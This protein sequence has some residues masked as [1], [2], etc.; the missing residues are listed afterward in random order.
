MTHLNR[1]WLKSFRFEQALTHNRVDQIHKLARN[2]AVSIDL[3][4]PSVK[5]V[6]YHYEINDDT[7][8]LLN[9]KERYLLWVSQWKLIYAELTGLIR[10]FKKMRKTLNFPH[11]DHRLQT[12]LGSNFKNA[13]EQSE[14]ALRSL[15][16]RQL[17]RLAETAQV[18]LNARYLGKM[19]SSVRWAR[20]EREFLNDLKEICSRP[21]PIVKDLTFDDRIPAHDLEGTPYVYNTNDRT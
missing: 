3:G 14:D 19:A 8:A 18:L 12:F 7:Y 2:F 13:S 17:P 6:A 1:P 10:L 11:K 5:H 15:A 21:D 4:C 16:H 9:D 20:A